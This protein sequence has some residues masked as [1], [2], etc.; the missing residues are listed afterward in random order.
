MRDLGIEADVILFHP[1]DRGAWGF[2][3]MPAEADDHYLRYVVARLAAYRNVWWSLANE[4]D[5]MREKTTADWDRFF[6][7]VQHDDPFQHL[8][9]IHNGTRFYNHA[10]PWVTHVSVQN[11]A[12]VEEPGRAELYRDVWE[13]P[14]VYDEVKYEGDI[15]SR[16]GH[17]TPE[18][19]VERFWN[20]TVAG[21]Y[22]GH[23]ETY[24]DPNE[25]LWWS[26]GGVLHGQSPARIAFLR[27]ILADS[28]STGIDPIDKWQDVRTGGKPGEYYLIYFGRDAPKSWEFALPKAGLTDGM[29]FTA[30]ILDTWAMTIT[31]VEG[32]FAVKKK[33]NYAFADEHGRAIALPGK[34]YV[35]L[36]IKRS[37]K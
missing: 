31:P 32:A 3:R 14:V 18:E 9:S 33:T 27:Q 8:R 29:R 23:G 37:M 34:P 13:K 1:Y 16:W 26:K 25:I 2:D 10:Q 21:T 15:P 36:R 28:P 7:M 22:V 12:A 4:F 5:F 35:A 30:E 17:I 19:L 24:L 6:Q 20:G 11:G